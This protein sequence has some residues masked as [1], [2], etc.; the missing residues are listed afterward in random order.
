M[1][2]GARCEVS[3]SDPFG[4][5]GGHYDP[6]GCAHPYHKGD[7]PPLFGADGYAF[8]AVLTNR[9]TVREIVGKAVIIH[10]GLDDFTTQ[11]AGNAGGEDRLRRNR[12]D[13]IRQRN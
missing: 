1:H 12:V 3:G 11:P 8:S 4:A 13:K 9:I 6:T 5:A 2:E 7:L 10:A